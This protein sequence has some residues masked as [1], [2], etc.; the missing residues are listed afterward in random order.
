MKET[1][2]LFDDEGNQPLLLL[3]ARA[4]RAGRI[5][6]LALIL[7]S[8]T[9]LTRLNQ[10]SD[11]GERPLAEY[12]NDFFAKSTAV[13]ASTV[14]LLHAWLVNFLTDFV[15]IVK[16]PQDRQPE[17][18]QELLSSLPTCPKP[19]RVLVPE[20]PNLVQQFNVLQTFARCSA[21]ALAL[22]RYRQAKGSWPESL[23]ALT[24]S[25]LPAIPVDPFDGK[26]LRYRQ[27]P[28]GVVVYS[29]GTDGKDN[30]GKF[31]N[32]NTYRDGTDIGIRLWNVDKRLSTKR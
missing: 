21:V 18:L 8:K 2:A 15:E 20:L 1:Q 16:L 22:E 10:V 29:I 17:K 7:E 12:V 31:D 5:E 6:L 32:L 24:P 19:G 14:Q 4:L 30:E 28:E 27:Y 13:Q 25:Y 3:A 11:S 9:D 23:N 26:P